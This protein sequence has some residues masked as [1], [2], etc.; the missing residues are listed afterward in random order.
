MTVIIPINKDSQQ[1][2]YSD[3]LK[4]ADDMDGLKNWLDPL[5][6]T[7]QFVHFFNNEITTLPKDLLRE[8]HSATKLEN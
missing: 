3:I 8:V 1:S 6:R 2:S 7:S 5:M 4:L